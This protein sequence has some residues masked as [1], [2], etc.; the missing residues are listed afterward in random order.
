MT[1]WIVKDY[2]D[3][4]RFNLHSMCFYKKRTVLASITC[5]CQ[6]VKDHA[7][8]H[9]VCYSPYF[10]KSCSDNIQIMKN[11]SSLKGLCRLNYNTM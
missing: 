2:F 9:V 10:I 5:I 8:K 3:C 4:E 1:T 7:V 6:L 11:H